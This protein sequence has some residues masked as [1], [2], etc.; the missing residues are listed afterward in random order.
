MVGAATPVRSRPV[1][2]IVPAVGVAGVPPDVIACRHVGLDRVVND[3]IVGKEDPAR[4]ERD[5]RN[6]IA[7]ES[8]VRN[9]GIR[10]GKEAQALEI[11]L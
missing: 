7:D 9:R 6:L 1:G 4:I 11:L 2:P 8:V 10:V 5:K 3:V